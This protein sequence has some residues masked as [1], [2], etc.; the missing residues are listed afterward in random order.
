[1]K[2]PYRVFFSIFLV[3]YVSFALYSCSSRASPTEK[4]NG[5]FNAEIRIKQ[6]DNTVRADVSFGQY[7][8]DEARDVL[9]TFIS[10]ESVCG[11]TLEAKNG[12]TVITENGFCVD[13]NGSVPLISD[14]TQMLSIDDASAHPR[15]SGE[16]V[17]IANGTMI[18]YGKDGT[19]FRAVRGNTSVEILSFESVS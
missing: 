15:K 3:L 5:A 17:T 16:P 6:G 12:N 11:I 1:M 2:R 4:L 14:L 8:R 18:Y 13:I 7:V 19:P 9:V 10:P